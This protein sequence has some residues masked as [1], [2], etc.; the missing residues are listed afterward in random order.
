MRLAFAVATEV[1]PEILLL[2]E[3]LVGDTSFQQKCFERIHS[4]Q[5]AGKTICRCPTPWDR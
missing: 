4:F 3:I 5:Q 1:D 2:D